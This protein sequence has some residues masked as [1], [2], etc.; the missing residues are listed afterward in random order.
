MNPISVRLDLNEYIFSVKVT[1]L[2]NQAP[3]PTCRDS[4]DDFRG[5]REME[6][7]ISHAIRYDDDG[8]I[9]ESGNYQPWLDQLYGDH[10]DLIEAKLWQKVDEKKERIQ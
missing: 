9:A 2:I 4:A 1:H 3:D 10:F 6:W 8:H 7:H 5:T